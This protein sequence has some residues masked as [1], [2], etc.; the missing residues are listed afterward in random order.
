MKLP[1][2]RRLL[3]VGVDDRRR[4]VGGRGWCRRCGYGRAIGWNDGEIFYTLREAQIVIE[5]WRSPSQG[6]LDEQ[7]PVQNPG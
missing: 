3:L 4:G 2:W 5:S 7:G 1:R 6:P